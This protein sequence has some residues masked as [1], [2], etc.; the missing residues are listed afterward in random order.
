MYQ[1][2]KFKNYYIQIYIK[3]LFH[4]FKVK[5]YI[6]KNKLKELKTYTNKNKINFSRIKKNEIIFYKY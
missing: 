4:F 1:T 5:N 6:K 3:K 2:I